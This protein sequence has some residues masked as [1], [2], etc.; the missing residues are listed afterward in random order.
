MSAPSSAPVP[1]TNQIDRT[2]DRTSGRGTAPE[3]R[4]SLGPLVRPRRAAL[5]RIAGW[6]SLLV[7]CYELAELGEAAGV[8]AP[9]LLAGLLVG[10][11]LALSGRVTAPFPRPAARASQ[12]LVGVV[13]GSYLSPEA[14]TGVAGTAGPLIVITAATVAFAVGVAALLARVST[15]PRT[16][17]VLGMVPGG[18][19]AIVSC[20]DDL[21]ADS[22]FVAFTQYARVGIV[23]LTAPAVA[24]LVTGTTTG[25]QPVVASVVPQVDQLVQRPIHQIGAAVTLTTVCVAGAALGRRLGLPAPLLLGP[26]IV[27]AVFSLTH[28]SDGYCPDGPFKDIVFVSVGLE[29]GL[30]FSRRLVAHVLRLLPQL[31]AAILVLC[32]VCAG[33]AGVLGALTGV[34]FLDAYLATTPGGINAVLAASESTRSDVALISTVQAV[35][36][37]VVVLAVPPIIRW[38]TK[39]GP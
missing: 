3:R 25:D 30:R 13:M 17:L 23:A 11:V 10:M 18:S 2:S 37:F 24:F 38:V 32:A 7:I 26:M 31:L 22:R 35:R 1:L 39:C 29:V 27:A 9:D 34:P 14:L 20:A 5:L 33:L 19:A 16:D 15:I 21:G 8:P 36:L 12:A 6:A 4:R 28:A